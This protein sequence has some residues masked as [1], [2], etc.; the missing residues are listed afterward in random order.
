VLLDVLGTMVELLPPELALREV[1]ARRHGVALGADTAAAA[2]AAEIAYYREHHLEG[3][4]EASL[5]DLRARCREVLRAGLAGS[6]AAELSDDALGAA[7]AESLRFRAYP[8]VRE[9][10]AGMRA[11]GQRVVAVSNWDVSLSAVLREVGIA[12]ALDGAVCS[13]EVG[14]A[15][16][17]GAIFE[18]ALALAQASPA[19]AVHVGDSPALDVD[20]ALAAGLA[21]V[22]VRRGEDASAE[23]ARVQLPTGVPVARSLT[24]VAEL[25]RVRCAA[26]DEAAGYPEPGGHR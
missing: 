25:V 14:A 17:A 21:A 19:E 5:A 16:P 23:E 4:D 18:A 24:E 9:A 8:E 22:L 26:P 7:L 6:A 3:R 13:A 11:S 12:D 15:K 2:F 1:L 20:G 10:L